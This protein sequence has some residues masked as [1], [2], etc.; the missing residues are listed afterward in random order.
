MVSDPPVR[1]DGKCTTCKKKRPASARFDPF[2]STKCCRKHHGIV[3]PSELLPGPGGKRR[4]VSK[5]A[6]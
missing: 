5:V 3:F 6:A 2:C 4:G 1:K